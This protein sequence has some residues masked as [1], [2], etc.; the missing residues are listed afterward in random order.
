[1]M[2]SLKSQIAWTDSTWNPVT[3]C[4]KVS[5]GCLNC[6]AERLTNRLQGGGFE[7]VRMHP[8]RLAQVG[9]FR[10]LPDRRGKRPHMVFVNSMSDLFH[11]DIT[12]AFVNQIFDTM[13]G[14]PLTIFQCLTKRTVRMRKYLVDRYA[15]TGLPANIWIGTSV[16]SNDVKARIDILRS[17]PERIGPVTAFLSVEP[18]VGPTDQLDFSDLQ[19]IITG[20]ESGPSCRVMERSWLMASVEEAQKRGVALFHKQSGSIRSHPNFAEAPVELGLKARFDWLV[21]NGWEVL[22]DEKG[23]ATIDHKTYRELP[24]HYH[25]LNERLNR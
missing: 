19:W 18:I 5:A 22:P 23:G 7:I 16:E 3:G 11:Q 6:Y 8:N 9:K 13:E 4:T 10:P 12:E 20:G 17:I 24:P 21:A 1:M 15:S 25:Q 14:Q 2:V